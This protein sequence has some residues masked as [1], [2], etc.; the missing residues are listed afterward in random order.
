MREAPRLGGEVW[1]AARASLT[2]LPNPI[3][4]QGARARRH[5]RAWTP[6][7]TTYVCT[8]THDTSF[9]VR[10]VR[11]R[12]VYVWIPQAAGQAGAKRCS[13]CRAPRKKQLKI[14]IEARRCHTTGATSGPQLRLLSRAPP[15][16]GWPSTSGPAIPGTRTPR[17]APQQPRGSLRGGRRPPCAGA[18]SRTPPHRPACAWPWRCACACAAA[19]PGRRRVR[20]PCRAH[21]RCAPKSCP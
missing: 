15:P 12:M 4:G 13:P 8:Y 6:Q 10:S 3:N 19:T 18:C 7:A 11:M 16:R 1:S 2:R 9:F 14:K 5:V 21:C 20:V 17:R